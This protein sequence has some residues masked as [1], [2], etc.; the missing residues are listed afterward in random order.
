MNPDESKQVVEHR[1]LRHLDLESLGVGGGP[2]GNDFESF[3]L[4]HLG[5][6]DEQ[7]GERVVPRG[8]RCFLLR[9]RTRS[10]TSFE[11]RTEPRADPD[12]PAH[13]R[14]PDNRAVSLTQ[15]ATKRAGFVVVPEV[16]DEIDL[17]AGHAVGMLLRTQLQ[18]GKPQS[19]AQMVRD[20][21]L[22]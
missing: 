13:E 22:G 5:V 1:E 12:Q 14:H 4:C 15:H 7:C 21:V 19:P 20:R 2:R 9:S 16:G 6:A 3:F 17:L 18:F 8:C 11:H 10:R